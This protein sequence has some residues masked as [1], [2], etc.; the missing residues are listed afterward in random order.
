MGRVCDLVKQFD[1][2]HTIEEKEVMEEVREEVR[3]E[4]RG[5]RDGRKKQ[6][7][8]TIEKLKKSNSIK[9]TVF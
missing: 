6:L 9:R 4:I 1:Y 8:R 2:N 7:H 3:E 5:E